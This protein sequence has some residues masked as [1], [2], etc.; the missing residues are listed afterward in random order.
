[1][2][3]AV[4]IVCELFI[5]GTFLRNLFPA[6]P[7]MGC[8]PTLE[9]NYDAFVGLAH[10]QNYEFPPFGSTYFPALF[11]QLPNVSLPDNSMHNGR[12]SKRAGPPKRPGSLIRLTL[13]VL[14]TPPGM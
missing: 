9:E 8:S 13:S 5:V 1:V 6:A 4:R 3:V 12:R 7:Y 2:S 14:P 10:S 11:T